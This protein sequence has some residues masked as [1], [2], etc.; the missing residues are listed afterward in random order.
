MISDTRF[1]T[2][3]VAFIGLAALAMGCG[4]KD[5]PAADSTK[6]AA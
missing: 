4:K 2:T 3:I 6:P 5:A 1:A